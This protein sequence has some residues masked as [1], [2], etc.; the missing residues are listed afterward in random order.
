MFVYGYG[1]FWQVK[2]PVESK[3]LYSWLVYS[4]LH[5]DKISARCFLTENIMEYIAHAQTVCT[6]PWGGGPGTHC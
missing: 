3:A 1:P 6:S 4:L 2:L 5:T